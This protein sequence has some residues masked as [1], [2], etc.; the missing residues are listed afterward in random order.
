MLVNLTFNSYRKYLLTCKAFNS[1]LH[2]SSF[3]GVKMCLAYIL[4]NSNHYIQ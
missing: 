3:V 2:E 1:N 4:H